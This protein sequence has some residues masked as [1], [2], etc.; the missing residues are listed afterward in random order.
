VVINGR[1]ILKIKNLA[2]LAA[3]AS[4]VSVTSASALTVGAANHA[5]H[6]TAIQKVD[7]KPHHKKKHHT[8]RKRHDRHPPKGWHRHNKRPHDWSRR[9]CLA[10]GSIWWCP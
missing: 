1:N 8:F 4:I 9:G 2:L 10:I 6:S 3:A 5:A 7:H